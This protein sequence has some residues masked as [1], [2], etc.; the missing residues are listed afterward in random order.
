MPISIAIIPDTIP[1]LG[2]D[3]VIT[4]VNPSSNAVLASPSMTVARIL[5]NDDQHGVLSFNS[6][7]TPLY[8]VIDEE[9]TSAVRRLCGRENRWSFW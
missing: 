6:T 9:T 5:A 3:I 1:E 2:E 4:L 7:G 8:F